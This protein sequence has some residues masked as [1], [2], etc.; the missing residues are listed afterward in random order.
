MT[1]PP[2]YVGLRP[3]EFHE[4]ALFYGRGEHIAEMVRTLCKGHFLAVIGSSGSGKSSLV[5]AGL[6]PAIAA[7]FM[8]GGEDDL[9]WRFVLMRPGNDP[10]DNLLR[11]LLPK[12]APGQSLDPD[13]VE[14][15][16][17]TLR[18]GP[19]GLV[20]AVADSL[21]PESARIVVLVDQF[22]EIFRFLE[23]GSP[24]Q[25]DDSGSVADRR[26]TALAFVD[27]LLATAAECDPHVNVVLTMRSEYLGECEAFLGLSSAVSKF[28]F[29]TP[30]M[31][32]EQIQDIIERPIAA[33]GGR[34]E[35]QVVT[36]LLNS[37]GPA[38]DQLPRVEHALLRMWDRACKIREEQPEPEQPLVLTLDDYRAVGCFETA[39]DLHG[40][41]LYHDLGPESDAGQPSEKQRVAERLFRSLAVRTSQGTLVRRLSTLGEV[42][43][44]AAAPE[45]IVAEVVEHFRQPGCNFLVATPAEQLTGET[46][47][48]ISH[49]S[50]LRQWKRMAESVT[51]EANAAAELQHL[52]RDAQIWGEGNRGFLRQPELGLYARWRERVP[53]PA[54]ALRYVREEEFSAADK[55]LSASTRAALAEERKARR[56]L[57]VTGVA[58]LLAAIGGASFG[59]VQQRKAEAAEEQ[60][61]YQATQAELNA[62]DD[63]KQEEDWA[64]RLVHLDNALKLRKP[65][66]RCLEL[67]A[68]AAAALWA[69]LRYGAASRAPLIRAVFT[70]DNTHIQYKIQRMAWS[71][72]EALLAT[73]SG[74]AVRLWSV[75]DKESVS[76]AD[77][78]CSTIEYEKSSE[79]DVTDLRFSKDGKLLL[80]VR[81]KGWEAISVE[82]KEVIYSSPTEENP[83]AGDA[84]SPDGTQVVS[85]NGG[86]PRVIPTTSPSNPSLVAATLSDGRVVAWSPKGDRIALAD[87]KLMITVYSISKADDTPVPPKA[88]EAFADIAPLRAARSIRIQVNELS[89]NASGDLLLVRDNNGAKPIFEIWDVN[90]PTP[91]RK[92][93]S[94]AEFRAWLPNR[95]LLVEGPVG[96]GPAVIL[97]ASFKNGRHLPINDISLPRFSADG[98]EVLFIQSTRNYQV[99]NLETGYPV[100][101]PFGW[102]SSRQITARLSLRPGLIASVENISDLAFWDLRPEQRRWHADPPQP[103]PVAP[104]L[105]PDGK[106]IA[107]IKVDQRVQ[108]A[109]SDDDSR[110]VVMISLDEQPSSVRWSED[111]R[112]LGIYSKVR[113]YIELEWDPPKEIEEPIHEL[114]QLLVYR[115]TD[116]PMERFELRKAMHTWKK[117]I[118]PTWRKLVDWWES[119]RL[120]EPPGPNAQLLTDTPSDDDVSSAPFGRDPQCS[121]WV[122]HDSNTRPLTAADLR[123]LSDDELWTARNEIFARRGVK[124]GGEKYG[125]LI[126]K[127]GSEFHATGLNQDDAYDR[128]NGVEKA[129]ILLIKSTES[130]RQIGQ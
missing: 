49:E 16:R 15:R 121:K 70:P 10:Y 120:S 2:P 39:L 42:A 100:T 103:P 106:W 81:E 45:Q 80:A 23:R 59:L 25:P 96:D 17:R 97:N 1:A 52:V 84:F 79:G 44:V 43:S 46:T 33:A 128:M 112:H 5:R 90:S 51:A 40:E 129:N 55:Y 56:R 28:Q 63:L 34:I 7:G 4:A 122:F 41:Q 74:V 14:F 83:L 127:L 64:Q 65:S 117:P 125:K 60:V 105:S 98:P 130:L 82:K 37:L 9:D 86:P 108:V 58:L 48:D 73:A 77:P 91:Q 101:P 113:G 54:W 89:F 67:H 116:P 104:V 92:D 114:V 61:T 75:P 95:S 93:W 22:E 115:K 99:L 72:T 119:G 71:P 62:A 35:P 85:R 6:L 29:L 11:E 19:R 76:F 30:R 94:Q 78:P 66:Q 47:L 124:A 69:E 38:Q 18:G 118:D 68:E 21:L 26:N 36:E 32:R 109:P 31:T 107:D 20:E 50:L 3:F 102:W 111:S 13:I 110:S 53:S 27:M 24:I 87:D 12:L 123:R 126:D 88:F 8:N 57:L